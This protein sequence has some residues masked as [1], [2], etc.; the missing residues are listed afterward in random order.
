MFNM[1]L[2]TPLFTIFHA[3]RYYQS[4]YALL[5]IVND[6]IAALSCIYDLYLIQSFSVLFLLISELFNAVKLSK[7]QTRGEL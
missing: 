4:K 1:T 2:S 3:L 6:V 7:L 5:K